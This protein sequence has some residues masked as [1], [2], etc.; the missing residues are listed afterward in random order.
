MVSCWTQYTILWCGL[1][2]SSSRVVFWLF[3]SL[4]LCLPSPPPPPSFSPSLKLSGCQ[5]GVKCSLSLFSLRS[6]TA[7]LTSSITRLASLCFVQTKQTSR[8]SCSS[9]FYVLLLEQVACSPFSFELMITNTRWWTPDE[10]RRHWLHGQQPHSF[11]RSNNGNTS[12]LD[13]PE[14]LPTWSRQHHQPGTNAAFFYRWS[15]PMSRMEIFFFFFTKLWK[16]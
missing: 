5:S 8:N 3:L 12:L 1:M 15:S 4:S 7:S 11:T 13:N 9:T 10:K 16:K 14:F 6:S 2:T